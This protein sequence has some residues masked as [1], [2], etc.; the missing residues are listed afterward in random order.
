[1]TEKKPAPAR[2]QAR[3]EKAEPEKAVPVVR[4][5]SPAAQRLEG[6]RYAKELLA[7]DPGTTPFTKDRIPAPALEDMIRL[8]HYLNT[9]R[10]YRD[11]KEVAETTTEEGK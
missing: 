8:A 10:D 11:R 4:A 6:L 3:T 9:G 7:D 5:T 1:M 2:T